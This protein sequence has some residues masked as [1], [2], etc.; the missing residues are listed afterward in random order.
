VIDDLAQFTGVDAEVR[1]AAGAIDA[2]ELPFGESCQ[3]RQRLGAG[4]LFPLGGHGGHVAVL[5]R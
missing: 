3:I 2:E 4:R 1:A 5:G